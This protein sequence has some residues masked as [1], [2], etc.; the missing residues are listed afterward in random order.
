MTS[1]PITVVVEQPFDFTTAVLVPFL[2]VLISATIAVLLARW[3]RLAS[4]SD[5]MHAQAT[6]LIRALNGVGRAVQVGDDDQEEACWVQYEQ[7]LNAFAAQ[8]TKR[9][10]VVAKYVCIVVAKDGQKSPEQ[11]SRTMLWLATALEL[12]IRGDLRTREF[13]R[14][15][16]QDTTSWV[17]HIDLG[18]WD[19]V[20]RGESATGIANLPTA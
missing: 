18:E 15:M 7:E 12:W 8:L 5:R 6:Q 20:T 16:P 10:S 9:Q 4:K 17:E 3:E 11:T 2:T 14:N 19:A 1:T 13:E